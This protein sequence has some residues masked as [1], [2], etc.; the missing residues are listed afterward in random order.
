MSPRE[1][2]CPTCKAPRATEWRPFCS[3]RC[4]DQDLGHWLQGDYAIKGEPVAA[5][6]V[7]FE[8]ERLSRNG[9]DER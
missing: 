1:G 4:A 2:K 8:A 6:V 3:K 7:D 9:S 5:E